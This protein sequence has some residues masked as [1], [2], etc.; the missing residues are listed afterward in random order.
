MKIENPGLEKINIHAIR[1]IPF[2][3]GVDRLTEFWATF[4]IYSNPQLIGEAHVSASTPFLL[5]RNATATVM[6]P[7]GTIKPAIQYMDIIRRAALLAYKEAWEDT[8]R[9]IAWNA[10]PIGKFVDVL[11]LGELP[12]LPFGLAKLVEQVFYLQPVPNGKNGKSLIITQ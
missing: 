12:T 5:L 10:F 6:I 1:S 8:T 3:F 4:V 11:A 9:D 7:T 2:G